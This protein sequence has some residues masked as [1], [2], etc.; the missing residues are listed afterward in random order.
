MV[1]IMG[2]SGT[3]KTTLLNM[4]GFLD[5]PTAGRCLFR[6]QDV[7]GLSDQEL[8]H[9]RS[10]EIGFVFQSFN[11]LDRL[12][13]IDNLLLPL[14]YAETYPPDAKER[15]SELLRAVGLEDRIR[16]RPNQLSGGQ[17]QRVAIARALI[18][19][20]SLILADEPTGNLDSAAGEEVLDLFCE[21]NANGRT[22]A[23]VTHDPEVAARAP[24]IVTL[25]DG[26]IASDRSNLVAVGA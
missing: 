23:L 15:A 21:L 11:L 16:Y 26:R 19:D 4:I 24:R 12:R 7:T 6:G 8:S 20:P 14:L 25:R 10:R 17:Q 5:V 18:N 13:V 1:A 2:P 3:G 9:L 22:V